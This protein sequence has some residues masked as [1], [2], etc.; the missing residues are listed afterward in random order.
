MGMESAVVGGGL[1]L[2]GGVLGGQSA[3]D[4]A[5]SQAQAQI[6]AAKI[7]ADAA[8]FRPVGITTR[9]GT[10]NFQTDAQGNLIGAGY[11]VSPEMQAY[12]NRLSA[13]QAQQLGQAEQAPSQYAPLTGAAG[14]LFNLGQQYLAQSPQEA[15]QQYMTNQLALLAPSR[16][17]QSAL[18]ANQLQNTGRTGLSVAQGGNLMSANPEYAALANARAMQDL[19]LAANAQQAGQQQTAFGAGLFG[20][21]AGLLGQYQQGQVGALSPFQNTLGVQSGIES[22]GQNALTLGSQ[23]GGNAATA[24][25]NAGRFITQGAQAAAPAAYQAASYNPLATGLIN[26]GTNQQLTQG[27]A[28]WWNTPTQWTPQQFQ[29]QQAATYG[30]GNAGFGD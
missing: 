5:R 13:L 7:A 14:S 1:S 20:Q 15:A 6:D 21:G 3:A 26:A 4:A 25:A 17:Q 8:K 23:L 12:Q 19:Q 22:L 18:L 29:Q 10:S 28:N 30:S 16:E 2:L 27:I 24:G 11:N 9:Y